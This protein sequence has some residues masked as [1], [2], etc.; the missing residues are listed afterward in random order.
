MSNPW[1]KKNPFMSM[2]LSAAHSTANAAR[3]RIAAEVKRESSVA[4]AQATQDVFNFWTGGAMA[5]PK[6]QPK[7]K[8]KR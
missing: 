2:W 8:T 4:L 1:L 7:R 5:K 6:A 3:S